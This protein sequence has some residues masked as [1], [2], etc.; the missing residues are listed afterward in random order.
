[1]RAAVLA[2]T[3]AELVA[4]G[5]ADL[6]VEGVALRAGVHKT[7]VYRR[8]TDRESLVADALTD[9]IAREVPIPNTGAVETDL[10][11]HARSLVSWLTSPIG[12]AIISTMISGEHIPEIAEIKRRFFEDRLRRAEPIVLRAIARGELP[13]GTDSGQ[14]IKTL[15]AP[16][17][18]RL[19][20]TA[21]QLDESTAADAA[22]VA[23]AA[24]RAGALQRVLPG[25]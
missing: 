18:L 2:A 4:A 25:S 9:S 10:R 3:L 20:I 24:A 1:V 23:V 11:E 7:T 15:I 5:Y 21:E 12:D 6:S 13:D 19:L 8:W 17:Y 22:R 16:I 14:V